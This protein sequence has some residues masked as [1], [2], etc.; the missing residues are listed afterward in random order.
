MIKIVGPETVEYF[1][2]TARYVDDMW[3]TWN[4]KPDEL[5]NKHNEYWADQERFPIRPIDDKEFERIPNKETW[6]MFYYRATLYKD[7]AG[8]VVSMNFPEE[9]TLHN[10]KPKLIPA[11]IGFQGLKNGVNRRGASKVLQKHRYGNVKLFINKILEQV[12]SDHIN[13]REIIKAAL[14]ARKW[15]RR[16][17]WDRC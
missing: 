1:Q 7:A 16:I 11:V 13:T 3:E 8:T 14:K 2:L 9:F 15:A 12:R 10:D 6:H 17:C 4:T 5:D